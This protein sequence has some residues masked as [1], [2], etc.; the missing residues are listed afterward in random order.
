M[1]LIFQILLLLFASKSWG[2]LYPSFPAT[3]KIGIFERTDEKSNLK[4]E[5]L[6]GIQLSKGNYY[7][8][9]VGSDYILI[10]D[11]MYAA[12]R[13]RTNKKQA[14]YLQ[15]SIGAE[16]RPL[17]FLDES[18]FRKTYFFKREN[19]N[20]AMLTTWNVERAGAWVSFPKYLVNDTVN[21]MNLVTVL[22][23]PVSDKLHRAVWKSIWHQNGIMFELYIQT[24][25]HPPLVSE[26]EYPSV[27]KTIKTTACW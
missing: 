20:W 5:F 18:Q 9:T 13:D 8:K 19:G 25:L 24:N 15:C 10:F 27:V 12:K 22:A 16:F 6:K 21:D 7:V 4:N 26:F 17:G 14:E 3:D 1:Q 11:Q 23:V 2:Q